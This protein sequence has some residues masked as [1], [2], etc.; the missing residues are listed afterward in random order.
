MI[1]SVKF[2]N[3]FPLDWNLI[4]FSDPTADELLFWVM[5]D[6]HVSMINIFQMGNLDQGNPKEQ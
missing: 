6:I 3:F 1:V 4:R 2:Q 5:I